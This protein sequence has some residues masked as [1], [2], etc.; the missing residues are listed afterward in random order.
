MDLSKVSSYQSLATVKAIEIK[1]VLFDKDIAS[2][3]GI[4]TNGGAVLVP[5]L[6][7]FKKIT[8]NDNFVNKNNLTQEG[9][10]I[11]ENGLKRFL[12]KEDFAAQF[13][14]TPV[15]EDTTPEE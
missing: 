14:T 6:K 1:E 4:Q 2:E 9:Y 11:F 15:K 7:K 5:K 13:E 12:S 3:K 8:V 10:L